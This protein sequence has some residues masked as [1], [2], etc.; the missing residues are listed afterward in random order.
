MIG[1]VLIVS[2]IALAA[3]AAVETARADQVFICND[4]KAITVSESGLADA[5]RHDPCV[6]AYFGR[7]AELRRVPLPTRRPAPAAIASKTDG[8]A[9]ARQIAR[10]ARNGLTASKTQALGWS[11]AVKPSIGSATATHAS[12]ASGHL[13]P[14]LSAVKGFVH[15]DMTKRLAEHKHGDYRRVFVINAKS[16]KQRWYTHSR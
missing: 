9:R 1:K 16:A 3:G 14:S 12:D 15:T 11:K 2:G 4:G 7:N 6:A 5:I 13:A 10:P 8:S